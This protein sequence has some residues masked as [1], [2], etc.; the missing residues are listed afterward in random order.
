MKSLLVLLLLAFPVAAQTADIDRQMWIPFVEGVNTDKPELYVGIH[1]PEFHWVAPGGKGRVMD[2]AEYD[3]DSRMVMER[4]RKNGER[5]EVEI[6]FLERNVRAAFAAEKA[7]IRFTLF[8]DG[9]AQTSYG[10]A[11][12]FSRK[13]NGVW[14]MLVQYGSTEKGTAEMFAASAPIT[15]L[16]TTQP[17][18]AP[19]R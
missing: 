15:S 16:P 6:R 11:H 2:L 10:I 13:E 14:K 3:V 7:I 9:Q 17:S 19:S 12:Y 1:S 5:A 18:P 8:K 4:R